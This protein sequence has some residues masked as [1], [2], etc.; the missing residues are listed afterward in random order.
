VI[1]R[2]SCRV[3]RSVPLDKA[4]S[5][6]RCAARH[7]DNADNISTAYRRLNSVGYTR[8]SNIAEVSVDNGLT[9]QFVD[10]CA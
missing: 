9:G 5:A 6:L 8:L 4:G 10:C 1:K 3:V 2:I 7:P